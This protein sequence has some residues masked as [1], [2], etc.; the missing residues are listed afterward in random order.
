MLLVYKQDFGNL[1]HDLCVIYGQ[2]LVP[3]AILMN[4]KHLLIKPIGVREKRMKNDMS[5]RG[6]HFLFLLTLLII[7]L[8]KFL[9]YICWHIYA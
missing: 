4:F 3:G 8:I 5:Y 9:M 6:K 7:I 2:A 1:W